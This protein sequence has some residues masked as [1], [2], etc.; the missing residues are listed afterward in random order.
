VLVV[1]VVG[2]GQNVPTAVSVGVSSASKLISIAASTGPSVAEDLWYVFLFSSGTGTVSVQ[3]KTGA[4]NYLNVIAQSFTGTVTTAPFFEKTAT[5][6]AT[7]RSISVTVNSGTVGRRIIM[8]VAAPNS[9]SFTLGSGQENIL[10][11]QGNLRFADLNYEDSSTQ[12]TMSL[13]NFGVTTN[14]VTI[15]AAILPSS[16]RPSISLPPTTASIDEVILST[17]LSQNYSWLR[18]FSLYSD[19]FMAL[20]SEISPFKIGLGYM[21]VPM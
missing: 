18:G 20:N 21:S 2:Y 13:S 6:T 8:A 16:A 12:M 19:Q 3:T 10:S 5:N 9:S 7:G 11:T 14:L 15:G 17:A 1:V 4:N